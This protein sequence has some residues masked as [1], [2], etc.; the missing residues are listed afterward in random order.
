MALKTLEKDNGTQFPLHSKHIQRK[1]K[2]NTNHTDSLPSNVVCILDWFPTHCCME[3][4]QTHDD[5]MSSI[6]F[7]S[8]PAL[9]VNGHVPD[10]MEMSVT[11]GF[12]NQH[13]TSRDQL[14]LCFVV[15][16]V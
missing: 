1:R 6:T 15:S 3:T 10:K 11:G 16:V 13:L 2:K 4:S 12:L 9:T 8:L 7:H 14:S 5:K